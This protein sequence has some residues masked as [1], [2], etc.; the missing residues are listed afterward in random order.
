MARRREWLRQAPVDRQPP[1]PRRD[2]QYRPRAYRSLKWPRHIGWSAIGGSPTPTAR[3]NYS[4]A[5][6][7]CCPGRW[8][9]LPHPRYLRRQTRQRR[10]SSKPCGS[11]QSTNQNCVDDNDEQN[12]QLNCPI[13]EKFRLETRG[14]PLSFCLLAKCFAFLTGRKQWI[15]S[16]IEHQAIELSRPRSAKFGKRCIRARMSGKT[17]PELLT[18]AV[19]V[20]ATTMATPGACGRG[21]PGTVAVALGFSK[22]LTRRRTPAGRCHAPSTLDRRQ[23]PGGFPAPLRDSALSAAPAPRRV[24]GREELLARQS[25]KQF[26][27]DRPVASSSQASSSRSFA[28]P[29]VTS[30]VPVPLLRLFA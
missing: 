1:S 8:R 5:R 29:A 25:P 18:A 14:F 22:V 13:V 20:T 17:K 12:D 10:S 7:S 30:Q 21:L 11:A 27:R 9:A 26:F 16:L 3:E 19:L 24:R 28:W 4:K 2:H 6:C 23:V 15:Q